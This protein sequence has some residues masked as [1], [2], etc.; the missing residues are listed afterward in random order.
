M[1]IK[2]TLTYKTKQNGVNVAFSNAVSSR[3]N[4]QTKTG[5][6]QK[7]IP[8]SPGCLPA[9]LLTLRHTPAHL[10]QALCYHRH[11][12][13]VCLG[14]WISLK[15]MMGFLRLFLSLQK[16]YNY[17]FLYWEVTRKLTQH[18]LFLRIGF[19]PYR[20]GRSPV[21]WLNRLRCDSLLLTSHFL[22]SKLQFP[23]L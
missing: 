2:P 14:P 17:S 10:F 12:H 21:Q 11:S 15:T 7:G 1:L 13:S 3:E 23:C 5:G 20:I 16:A 6:E 18:S 4:Q 8:K 22:S 9:P 19:L